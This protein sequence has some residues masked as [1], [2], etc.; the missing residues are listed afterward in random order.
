MF[1]LHGLDSSGQG[2]KGQFF[3]EHFPHIHCPDFHGTL[4][5]RLRQLTN[6]CQGLTSPIFIGSSFGGLM[7]TCYATEFPDKV[8]RLI[9]LAPALNF[10]EYHL[11]KNKLQVPTILII[12]NNDTVTPPV[13]VIPLA[14]KTFSNLEIRLTEDDHMLHAAFSAISWHELLMD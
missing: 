5:D 3:A 2:T 4:A 14:Q 12:G 7:A 13:K 11:P 8:G 6:L 9:L 1:F 10:G